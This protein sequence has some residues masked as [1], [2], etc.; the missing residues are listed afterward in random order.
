MVKTLVLLE[1]ENKKRYGHTLLKLS[2]YVW[3]L[4]LLLFIT[5]Y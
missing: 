3:A 2:E 4:G 1:G 5:V